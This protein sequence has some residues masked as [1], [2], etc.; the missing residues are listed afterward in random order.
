MKDECDNVARLKEAADTLITFFDE[1]IMVVEKYKAE[2]NKH[3]AEYEAMVDRINPTVEPYS[4]V[5]NELACEMG[6]D[7]FLNQPEMRLIR[8]RVSDKAQELRQHLL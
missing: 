6:M 5:H 1:V 4:E 2:G 3:E 8:K 7:A